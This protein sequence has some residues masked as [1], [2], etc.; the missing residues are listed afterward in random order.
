MSVTIR[1][2]QDEPV[3]LA[4]LS[5]LSDFT[6]NF[7]LED[8][9]EDDKVIKSNDIEN[10][11]NDSDSDVSIQSIDTEITLKNP[12]HQR[13]VKLL[14]DFGEYQIDYNDNNLIITYK[15]DSA[16]IGLMDSIDC[17]EKLTI[18]CSSNSSKE[19]NLEIIKQFILSALPL[20]PCKLPAIN[21]LVL[22]CG[23]SLSSRSILN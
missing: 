23:L 1:L 22:S 9:E 17:L 20:I 11:D 14:A 21:I 8:I 7:V 4:V 2:K 3:T 19:E 5:Y 18:T 12:N 10:S 6:N 16:P 15:I 13:S